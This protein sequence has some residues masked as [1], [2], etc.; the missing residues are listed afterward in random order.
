MTLE[1]DT[2]VQYK[3]SAPYARS[4]SARS[5]STIPRSASIG[6]S[7]SDRLTLSE[8][9]RAAPLLADVDTGF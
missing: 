8:K 5:A 9:D 7:Q 2:E 1:P 6:Q 4:M 3:V